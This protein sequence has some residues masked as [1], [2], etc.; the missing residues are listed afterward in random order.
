MMSLRTS[1]LTTPIHLTL[2]SL[3]VRFEQLTSR[4]QSFMRGLQRTVDLHGISVDPLL[5]RANVKFHRQL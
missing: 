4:A 1:R 2:S 3:V 5:G